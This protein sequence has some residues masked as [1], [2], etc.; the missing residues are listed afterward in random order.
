MM[1]SRL[2]AVLAAATLPGAA[3]PATAQDLM[4]PEPCRLEMRVE[5]SIDWRGLYGRGYEV[6]DDEESF[7]VT[8]VTIRHE[9]AACD[10]FL[11]GTS[12]EAA[13]MPQLRGPYGALA[14]DVLRQPNGPSV[15]SQD[16]SGTQLSR[17]QG[18]F[19]DG[20]SAQQI[21]LYV[22]IPPGQFVGGGAYSGQALL[23]LFRS[24]LG[25]P[26]LEDQAAIDVV[27]SVPSTM[28]VE[29]AEAG[30]GNR[31][32]DVDLGNL[33]PGVQ[34]ALDFAVRSNA[35]VEVSVDS[36]NRGILAHTAGARG[37]PYRLTVA[38]QAVDLTAPVERSPATQATRSPQSIPFQITVDPQPGAAAGS[39]SDTLTITFVVDG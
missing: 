2:L 37:I 7:E 24:D 19:G 10:Y 35:P 22:A 30:P 39:Y 8:T 20:I 21:T 29:S 11:T 13:G 17:L 5:N 34:R 1:S 38:G 14:F 28:K 25:A 33:E 6:F 4:T 27:A 3:L 32:L 26:E 36:A 16:F 23:R 9:G 15:I 12:Q 31:A 18:R